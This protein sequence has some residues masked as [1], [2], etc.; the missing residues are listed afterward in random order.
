[1]DEMCPYCRNLRIVSTS[2]TTGCC[3]FERVRYLKKRWRD[4][5]PK[6]SNKKIISNTFSYGKVTSWIKNVC[7]ECEL[8]EQS[9][10]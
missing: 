4:G 10:K 3:E 6:C 9:Q 5:C 1:M 7:T 2:E 8:V